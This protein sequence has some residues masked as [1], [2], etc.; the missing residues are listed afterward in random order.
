LGR[1]PTPLASNQFKLL[2]RNLAHED[3]LKHT[4]RLNG[5]RQTSERIV[6]EE[7]AWLI[8]IGLDLSDREL[9]ELGVALLQSF[10]CGDEGSESPTESALACHR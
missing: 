3:R 8:G 10:C 4:D 6:V 7:R 5:C 2:G 1:A 9:P